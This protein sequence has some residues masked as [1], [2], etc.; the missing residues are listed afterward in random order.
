[1]DQPAERIELPKELREV[2]GL[3]W[4]DKDHIA[5]VQDEQGD[6]FVYDISRKKMIHDKDF[7]KRGDHEGVASDGEQLYIVRSDGR[8]YRTQGVSGKDVEHWDTPLKAQNDV[9]GI[10]W[11]PVRQRLL[12]ACKADPG[13][14][15][16]PK[17]QRAVYAFDPA[18]GEMDDAPVLVLALD[19]IAPALARRGQ[20]SVGFHFAPSAIAIHPGTGQVWVLSA[21]DPMIVVVDATARVIDA[22]HLDPLLFPQPEGLTFDPDGSLYISSEDKGHGRL[23]VFQHRTAR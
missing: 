16:D 6:L 17:N 21:K 11:D 7:G 9:E 23:L 10:C 15:L 5:M 22:T 3:A 18:S 14:G 4:W 2:S 8:I 13:A 12:L 20:R 1:M 19:S